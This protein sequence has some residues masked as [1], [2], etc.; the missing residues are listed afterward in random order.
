MH[1]KAFASNL[2][3]WQRCVA[4]AKLAVGATGWVA[5]GGTTEKGRE[6]LRVAR[7]EYESLRQAGSASRGTI[8]RAKKSTKIKSKRGARSRPSKRGTRREV[9]GGRAVRT[10]GG[11]AA[12]SLKTNARGCIVSKRKSEQ[13][14][15]ENVIPWAEALKQAK[16]ELGLKG[17]VVPANGTALH[18]TALMHYRS[19]IASAA[20][21][22]AM[23][24]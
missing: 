21:Q 20:I 7:A 24:D 18:K 1:G 2:T 9:L 11:L 12:E 6:V 5:V 10:R 22:D 19:R 3:P 16:F 8:D 4:K 23:P 13:A 14:K 17:W 15:R